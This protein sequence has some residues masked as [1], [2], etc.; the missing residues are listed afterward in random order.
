[1]RRCEG[2]DRGEDRSLGAR[3]A[4]FALAVSSGF[5]RIATSWSLMAFSRILIVGKAEDSLAIIESGFQG[6][7]HLFYD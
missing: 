3:R 4:C 2:G 7:T 1:M 6:T 5:G